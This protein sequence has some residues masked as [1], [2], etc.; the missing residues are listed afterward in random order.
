MGDLFDN[1]GRAIYED[2]LARDEFFIDKFNMANAWEFFFNCAKKNSSVH[3]CVLDIEIKGN[4]YIIRQLMLDE[5]G[6]PIY[7]NVNSYVGR[8]IKAKVLDDDVIQ[9]M[10]GEHRQV[11]NK[12]Y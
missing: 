11:M 2:I 3:S 8:Q 12:P 5:K 6:M 1:L 7:A 4:W 9:F 10:K